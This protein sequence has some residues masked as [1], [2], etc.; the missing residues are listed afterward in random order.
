MPHG[1]AHRKADFIHCMQLY[2]ENPARIAAPIATPPPYHAM[3]TKY[4]GFA[5]KT[6]IGAGGTKGL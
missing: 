3:V 5:R 6:L 2:A 4:E 1:A